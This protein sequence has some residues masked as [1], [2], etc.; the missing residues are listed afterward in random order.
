[1]SSVPRFHACPDER[2]LVAS[3]AAIGFALLNLPLGAAAVAA[4]WPTTVDAPA[5]QGSAAQSFLS[6]GTA[7][8]GPV[9]PVLLTGA[10][11]LLARRRDRFGLAATGLIGA[12]GTLITINGARQALSRPAAHSPRPV[13]MAGGAIFTALGLSLTVASGRALAAHRAPA[14]PVREA[15]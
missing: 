13:L 14:G 4:D 9:A 5:D 6:R 8:S 3:R 12:M 2:R 15:R 1:M 11:G 10:L 7:L